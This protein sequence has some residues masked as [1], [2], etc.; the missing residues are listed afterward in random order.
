MEGYREAGGR[1]DDEFE[2]RRRIRRV[3]NL[4]HAAVHF[5]ATGRPDLTKAALDNLGALL[6]GLILG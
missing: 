4:H 2:A 6:E 3:A 1:W 5:T